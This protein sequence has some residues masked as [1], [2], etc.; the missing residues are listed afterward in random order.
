MFR[1]LYWAY[2]STIRCCF[3][4]AEC[5]SLAQRQRQ[6]LNVAVLRQRY[7][8]QSLFSLRTAGL[9]F[10]AQH[11]PAGSAITTFLAYSSRVCNVCMYAVRVSFKNYAAVK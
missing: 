11:T 4:L 3:R 8:P 10:S 2:I 1:N 6:L 9:S 5:S 7:L